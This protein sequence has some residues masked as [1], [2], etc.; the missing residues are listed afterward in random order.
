MV[1]VEIKDRTVITELNNA[2]LNLN[3]DDRFIINPLD[4][5]KTD[6][7]EEFYKRLTCLFMNPEYFSFI[8]KHL[9]NIDLLPMQALILQEMWNRKFPM[10]VGTRG[11]G[12]A[13]RPDEKI[14]VK[15]GW[16][17]M[18]D[19]E[20]GDH[21]Y[22]SDGTL[23]NVIYKTELQKNLVMYRISLR[24]GRTI[25]CC[26]DHM[27]KVW[28]KNKNQD[29]KNPTIWSELKT[30]DLADNYFYVRKDSKS[31]TPKVCKEY[32]YALP[33]NKALMNEEE[34]ILPLHPYVVGVLLGDGTLTQN[35]IVISSRDSELLDRFQSLLPYGYVL[36]ARNDIDYAIIR[37][38]KKVLPFHHLCRE[39]KIWGHN[40]HT[41][42]IP[43]LYKFASY[44]QKLELIKGLMDTDGW[45]DC[46]TI[47]YYTVSEKLCND[48][49]DVIRSLGIS[50]SKKIKPSYIGKRRYADCYKIRIYTDQ[51]IFSLTRKLSYLNHKKSKAGESK[52]EKIFITNIERIENAEGYCIK[53]DSL[54]STYITK[55]YIV[56]H[57][58][59][60]LSLYCI[61]RA[62]LIPNRKIVVVGSAFRQ[63]KYLH[64]YMENIWKNAP[65]L[66]DMCDSNSGPRRDVDMCKMTINGSTISALPIGDG[67]KIRGQRANDIV[68]DEFASMSREVFE[69]VIAGFAAVSASPVENVKRMAME[70]KALEMGIDPSSLYGE[71]KILEAAK[72]NQI[73]ISGTAYYEFNHFAEYW[74]RWKTIIETR[75]DRK[76]IMNNVFNGEEIPPSFKWDDYSIIR[77]PVDLVPRGF[78]DEGQIARSKA[79]IHNGLY[80]MEFGAV[81]TKDSK[82]FFKRSLIESCVGTDSKPVKIASGDIYFDPLLRGNKNE[83][84][85]MAIDPASEVDNFSIIILELHQDH[86]RVVHCWTTTRKD[87]TERVKKGLTKENNFYSYCARK[88]RDLMNLFQIV[89]IAMDAQ[90]GGY[91]VAEAL[92]DNSQLQ[93][94]EIAIWP[95]IDE[96]KPQPSDDQPG[97]HILEMC[98]F[99]KYDWYSDA[100]HGL[101][102]DLEDK[103]LLFPRFDP[104]T[105]GLS[106]EED[107]A[108]NRL[109]DTL[110]D[111]VME[112][113]ELKNELSLIEVSES[114][115]GRMRWDTPEVKVGVGKKQRMRK[116]RYSALIMANMAGRNIDL[117][118]KQATYSAYGGFAVKSNAQ[119]FEGATFSGPNWFT[120]QMNNIY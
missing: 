89:H 15:N 7:P 28:D 53:V 24:D 64:D 22:S 84:Y 4:R 21:V 116:D 43:D 26:E 56:T 41:K 20:V 10:L 16:K 67:Q 81:F 61:L 78:M 82:G 1:N 39:V 87:H 62:S 45:S 5:L 117:G 68:A 37:S 75:G 59:F 2:W 8:C 113:E 60:L 107:K 65:I 79:T 93:P 86:R 80:L 114:I 96:E 73:I 101:R 12:K 6:D 57:N 69:N 76:A 85:V 11:L 42:F 100:N 33:V 91:S 46:R 27:W 106:I 13:I 49:M 44:N 36:K 88:I 31:K 48:F 47:E 19:I 109:Y 63:S 108:N 112:I 18:R 83:K 14:R 52:Y 30:K 90:G 110:E 29:P 97:L 74:K 92:H 99:A 55:D 58:T 119:R 102:K 72:S 120:S 38:D 94:G 77:I 70:A 32:R 95:I 111:C 35:A 34:S 98:Q 3:V 71:K 17:S 54:D 50:C 104:V 105:I 118:E 9:L 25:D 115:N 51:G 40:S 103:T 23:C 66:R